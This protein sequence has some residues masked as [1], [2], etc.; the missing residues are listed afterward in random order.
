MK[1]SYKTLKRYIKDIKP[2]EEIAQNLVMHTAE[3]EDI[4][5]EWE[6]LKDVFI[7]EVISAE[8]HPDSEK[9]K[10][11][12]VKVND[13]ELDIVCGAYN[14]RTWLKIPVAIVWAQISPDFTVIK[15]KIRWYTSCGM[16]ASEDELWLKKERQAWIMELPI[17]SPLNACMRD[18]LWLNNATL[19]IDNKAI[20]HRPDLFSH[21]GIIRE[22]YAI[23]GKK[24]DYKYENRDFSFLPSLRI[25]NEIP[26][27]VKRYIGLK[28]SWV[29]NSESYDYVKE[30]L[31]TS[32]VDSKGLL[33]DLSNYSLYM[34]GQPTHIFDANK[35]KWDIT[36]RF[37]KDWEKFLAL[38]DKEYKLT[39]NDI[40]I[41]DDEKILALWWIIGGKESSVTETTKNIII[42]WAN[43]DQ[44]TLRRTWKRL[45]IRTDSLNV[46]EKD[47]LAE[48]ALY[49][50]SLIVSEL[51]KTFSKL[52]LD[53]YSDLY[54]VKQEEIEVDYD[55]DF[56][57]KLIWKNYNEKEAK[58][59][60]E[61]LGIE[62]KWKKLIVP[63]WRKD[64][65]FK[66]D[67]AEEIARIDWY[68]KVEVNIPKVQLWAII[69]DNIYKIKN[70][71][72]DYFTDKGFFD[73][74][75]Y[76]FVNEVLMAKLNE[77]LEHLIPLKNPLSEDATHMKWSLIP[78]LMLSLEKNIRDKKDFKLF[79]IEKVFKSINNLSPSLAELSCELIDEHYCL[80]WIMTSN[81]EI[82]Y[83]EMQTILSDFFRKIGLTNF[84]YDKTDRIP[85]YAHPWRTAKIIARW[86]EVWIIW[87]IHPKVCKNFDIEKRVWFFEINIEKIKD[88]VFSTQKAKELSSFQ[89]SN[90][91]I[92]FVV[93]KDNSGKDILLTIEKT[94]L[95]LIEKVELFDV[96]ENEEKLVWQRS[97][98]FKVFIQKMDS[99][100]T[101]VDKNE[102]IKQII[103]KVEKK[104]WK[105]R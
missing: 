67:I 12:K 60:L 15:T 70:E 14:V 4:H 30:V 21:I 86:Q 2:V 13:E 40:V 101:D 75:T 64:L 24:F 20:N 73:M 72:R 22:I 28:I 78:N 9:L 51:E 94:D 104:G 87:E 42:E 5:Y 103:S 3:I 68:D 71:T 35:I 38:N 41:T 17:D 96:Y 49:W 32:W 99:E 34:Y 44:A 62:I 31:K 97:L 98:S 45:G 88:M 54:P 81:K 56:I 26:N 27:V 80:S 79:E 55:L 25:Q 102:L 83:F 6:H 63:A 92:S 8:K 18:Y 105:L 82:V 95:K 47:I 77:T 23:N 43:F 7:W 50:V 10:L 84:Y 59:I 48:T 37:A 29:S 65:N 46:F 33:I 39:E 36:I 91:D 100:I 1:I 66:A 19:E 57:N 74:Y 76:S 90:F 58:M 85:N 61:N 52:K 53:A 16:I 93:N 69:Q 11:C 89:W